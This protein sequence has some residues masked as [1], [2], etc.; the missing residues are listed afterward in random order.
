MKKTKTLQLRRD[1]LRKLTSTE[2]KV[3]AG[4]VSLPAICYKPTG[5]SCDCTQICTTG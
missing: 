4:G 1:V 2:T 3:V 5:A